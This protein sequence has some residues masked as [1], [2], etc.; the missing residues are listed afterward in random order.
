M[1]PACIWLIASWCL[2]GLNTCSSYFVLCSVRQEP[3]YGLEGFPRQPMAPQMFR[4]FCSLFWLVVRSQN[5]SRGFTDSVTRVFANRDGF[6]FGNQNI[7]A[8]ET[9]F[10]RCWRVFIE[11][12][13]RGRAGWGCICH[14][15]LDGSSQ[16]T[17]GYATAQVDKLWTKRSVAIRAKGELLGLPDLSKENQCFWTAFGHHGTPPNQTR[18]NN[19]LQ[20]KKFSKRCFSTSYSNEWKLDDGKLKDISEIKILLVRSQA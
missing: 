2:S 20:Q 15:Q 19:V 1:W 18:A 8:R 9:P 5:T 6:L 7:W 10:P 11:H 12:L 16:K 4:E 17:W 14:S 3:C 13:T